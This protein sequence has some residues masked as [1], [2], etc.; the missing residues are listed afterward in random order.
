MDAF[1]YQA[2]VHQLY[3]TKYVKD[4]EQLVRKWNTEYKSISWA[5]STTYEKYRFTYKLYSL[6]LKIFAEKSSR[7]LPDFLYEDHT[8]A[9]IDIISEILCDSDRFKPVQNYKEFINIFEFDKVVNTQ[10]YGS[11]DLSILHNIVL[12]KPLHF[13]FKF[14]QSLDYFEMHSTNNLDKTT[15]YYIQA[16]RLKQVL[17][18]NK[19]ATV[20]DQYLDFTKSQLCESKDASENITKL[21]QHVK[22][23]ETYQKEFED[24]QS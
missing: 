23:L 11:M 4:L 7:V 12:D 5:S 1:K 18:P 3:S 9:Q 21:K 15:K 20:L 6:S 2:A 13:K 14:N 22:A 10:Q 19:P 16:I 24:E 8:V 17:S